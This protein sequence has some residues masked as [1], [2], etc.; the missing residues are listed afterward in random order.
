MLTY[1]KANHCAQVASSTAQIKERKSWLQFEGLH[2]LRVYTRSRQ[3]YVAMLPCQV[4]VG[5][6]PVAVQIVITAV[7]GPKSLF[8]FF[9]AN[10]LGLLQIINEVVIVLP[11]AH[12]SPHGDR[13]KRNTRAELVLRMSD[14]SSEW[15]GDERLAE[16]CCRC[17]SSRVRSDNGHVQAASDLRRIP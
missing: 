11:S 17:E 6:V 9:C 1:D 3:V 10:I 2:H 16:G 4:F 13:E 14:S 8:D 5:T 12:G 7:Y 15:H